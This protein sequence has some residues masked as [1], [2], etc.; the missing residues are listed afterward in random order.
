VAANPAGLDA[1]HDLVESLWTEQPA[2]PARARMRFETAVIEV[3]SNIIKHATTGQPGPDEVTIELTLTVGPDRI[4][5]LFR[6]DGGAA[7]VD[8]SGAQMPDAMAEFGR[9]IALARELTDRFSYER[10]ASANFWALTVLA[11]GPESPDGPKI[12]GAPISLPGR[13][14]RQ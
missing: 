11:S 5:A 1:I 12:P 3:A 9:G 4:S 2:P 7:D 14:H 13:G 10:S 6:D 8:L